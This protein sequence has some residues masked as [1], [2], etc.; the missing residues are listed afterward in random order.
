MQHR[1]VISTRLTRNATAALVLA[2]LLATHGSS[3]TATPRFFMPTTR[4]SINPQARTHRAP[5][6]WDID[7]F[8]DLAYQLFVTAGQTGT[9]TPAGN[10]NTVDEVPDSSW[11]TNRIGS[12]PIT[13]EELQRGPVAGPAPAPA[14]W[15]LTRERRA[16]ARLPD[17]PPGMP[18]A[19]RGSSPST[20]KRIRAAP[21]PRS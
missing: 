15:T 11:F 17:S 12:G 8:Y 18:T 4:S 13:V 5:R 21:R 1:H 3:R 2:G 20:P 14:K 7:L 19:R 6:S 9:N 16:R 10:I